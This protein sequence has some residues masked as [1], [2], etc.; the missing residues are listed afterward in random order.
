MK[1]GTDGVLLGAWA[2]PFKAG[3]ASILDVGTGSGVIAL[4][5]AQR[6]P[7]AKIHAIDIDADAAAQAAE[8]F[9]A[10]PWSNRLTAQHADFLQFAQ[11]CSQKFDLIVSNPPFFA[12]SLQCPNDARTAARHDSALPLSSLILSAAALLSPDGTIC[13]IVPADRANDVESLCDTNSLNIINKTNVISIEGA[14]PKRILYSISHS[15]AQRITSSLT[16]STTSHTPTPE[17]TAL[18]DPFYLRIKV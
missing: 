5:M 13:I 18:V 6:F 16:I 9:S 4:M 17:Y 11:N 8:N 1:V 10:S 12:R 2:L 7:N 3:A 14:V 15:P